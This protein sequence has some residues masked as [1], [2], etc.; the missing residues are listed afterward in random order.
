MNVFAEKKAHYREHGMKLKDGS[1]FPMKLLEDAKD[2]HKGKEIFIIGS[3]PSLG[4]FPDNFFDHKISIGL[5]Y[6]WTAWNVT[7]LHFCHRIFMEML[8][9]EDDRFEDCLLCWPFQKWG[10][11]NYPNLL[12]KVTWMIWRGAATGEDDIREDVKAIAMRHL[13]D[14]G[15]ATM[16][17]V[18]HSAIYAAVIFGA[19]LVSLCGCEHV[20][21]RSLKSSVNHA[22]QLAPYYRGECHEGIDQDVAGTR[23]QMHRFGT[24]LLAD[25]FGRMGVRIERYYYP[26]NRYE[27]ITDIGIVPKEGKWVK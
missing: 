21:S 24:K 5:N 25:E 16:G 10:A 7:Y 22:P 4:D 9:N 23:V 19:N 11:E 3:G 18:L 17:T 15:Y 12:T 14:C 26:R 2:R 1:S 20:Y 27:D 13:D 6:A 8:L